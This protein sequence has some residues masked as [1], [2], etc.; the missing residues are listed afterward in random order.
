MV[1][2]FK[3]LNFNMSKMKKK[4]T[5]MTRIKLINADFFYLLLKK[6]WH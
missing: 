2:V 5:R 1:L 3:T 6:K 4:G